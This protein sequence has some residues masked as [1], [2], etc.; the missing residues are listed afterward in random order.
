[1]IEALSIGEH[2]KKRLKTL[3]KGNFQ[4][5]GLAQALLMPTRAW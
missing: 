3:S 2:R 5:V 1:M 4:R